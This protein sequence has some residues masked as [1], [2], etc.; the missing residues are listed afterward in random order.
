MIDPF[1]PLTQP[2]ECGSF[3]SM[4]IQLIRVLIVDDH[5]MVRLG[6]AAL[7]GAEPDIRIVAEAEDAAQAVAMFR[8][9]QPD[10][11]LMDAR[12]PGG[13]GNDALA[14]IRSEFPAARIIILTTYDLEEPVFEA[15]DNGAAGYL[16][17]S[18]KR[19]DLI[20]AVRLVHEGGRCFPPSF[21]EKLADRES[22][23]RLTPRETTTLGL[24]R[25]GL[26]NRDIGIALG[27]SENTAKAHVRA[28]LRKLHAA[29]RTE[30]VTTGFERGFL[31][32]D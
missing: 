4:S 19:R 25:R 6:L 17:K 11:T 31:K 3:H 21:D 2:V 22:E 8:D 13:T 28:I 16:L 12:M 23:G 1:G 5:S 26:S 30:A 9:H 7:L 20:A 14:A 24:L 27:V 29:D 15:F 10:V 18:I 32:I